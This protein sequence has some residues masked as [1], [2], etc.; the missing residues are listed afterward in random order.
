MEELIRAAL[1][2]SPTVNA[3]AGTRI[4]FGGNVQGT[5]R[6]RVALWTIDNGEG[7]FLDGPDGIQTGR[8]QADC[9]ADTIGQ[10]MALGRAVKAALHGYSGGALRTVSLISYRVSREGGSDEADRPYRVSLDFQTLFLA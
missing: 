10:A 3:L 5:Q 8:V 7:L 4:D 1:L 6:P 9:Y 2:A